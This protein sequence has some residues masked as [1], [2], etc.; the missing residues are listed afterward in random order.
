MLLGHFIKSFP[1]FETVFDK[2]S[3]QKKY[4]KT[5]FLGFFFV[6]EV[7]E[8]CEKQLVNPHLE[9]VQGIS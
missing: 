5:R 8:S 7:M 6:E 1:N 9:G 2:I 3:G 4:K